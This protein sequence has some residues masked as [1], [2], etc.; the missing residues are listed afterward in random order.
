MR[1]E[2]KRTVTED[3]IT[4]QG[5]AERLGSNPVLIYRYVVKEGV[6]D[7][8]RIGRSHVVIDREDI[9]LVRKRVTRSYNLKANTEEI[10]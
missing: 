6:C 10:K 7:Y 9:E 1:P 4:I 2:V 8:L 5:V 3:I